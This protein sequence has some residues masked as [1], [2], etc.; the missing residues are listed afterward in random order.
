M[1]NLSN[2]YKTLMDD[3]DVKVSVT[4]GEDTSLPEG[5]PEEVE[6]T[7]IETAEEGAQEVESASE[8]AAMY[9]N[10]L[11][12][13]KS[14]ATHLKTRGWDPEFVTLYNQNGR[15]SKT[16]GLRVTSMEALSVRGDYLNSPETIA[17]LEGM[18]DLAGKLGAK[19]KAAFKK[20]AAGIKTFIEGVKLRLLSDVS[21]ANRILKAAAKRGDVDPGDKTAKVLLPSEFSRILNSIPKLKDFDTVVSL[22]GSVIKNPGDLKTIEKSNGV[23]R[24]LESK[25]DF[26]VPK[27]HEVRLRDIKFKD[28]VKLA[29]SAKVMAQKLVDSFKVY[30][31]LASSL[32]S[33]TIVNSFDMHGNMTTGYSTTE[34]PL[35]DA[36]SGHQK[37]LKKMSKPTN[38]VIFQML[39]TASARIIRA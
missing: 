12:E 26:E 16:L 18:R 38:K 3:V 39:R 10:L 27:A 36:I 5:T 15:I 29:E 19:L 4:D 1:A 35:L 6:Q 21:N 31:Q 8:E 11:A 30:D 9:I 32:T 23:I 22:M 7:G 13:V 37:C 33:T 2:S 28:A 24:K 14:M 20:I 17:A 34:S 25:S